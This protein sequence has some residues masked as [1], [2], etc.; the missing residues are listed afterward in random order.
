MT[1]MVLEAGTDR[2]DD[3]P[4]KAPGASPSLIGDSTYDWGFKTTEQVGLNGRTIN[5]PRGKLVGGS[6]AINSHSVVYPSQ[7][8]HDGWEQYGV[9]GWS[10][11][12]I[13]PYYQKFQTLC[14]PA[15]ES[16]SALHLN[17]VYENKSR[18]SG[19]IHTSFPRHSNP[20][21]AAWAETYEALGC[22]VKDDPIQGKA[23]GGLTVTN[24]IDP[25]K[26]ERSHAGV[27]YLKPAMD[28][29][30]V[31]IITDAL[32]EKIV[33]DPRY[34]SGLV[35]N[36]VQ[37]IKSGQQYIA[38]A[39]REVI[40]CAGAFQSPQIF[41]LSGI[42]SKS[43]LD[44]H[45]IVCLYDNPNVGENLQDHLNIGPSIE[46][47]DGVQTNDA[48][49]RDP[50][51]AE[52]ARKAYE[53]DHSGPLAEGAAYSFAY[54]P[55]SL[56]STPSE[57]D[58]LSA[59]FAC[60]P[61]T[62]SHFKAQYS[63][64]SNNLLTAPSAT[65][66]LTLRQRHSDASTLAAARSSSDPGNFISVIA[67]LSH[68][69]SRGRVHIT[70]SSP[71][72]YPL[73]DPAYLTH[74]LDVEI[75][76]R[77]LHGIDRLL[78]HEPLASF[79]KPGGSRLPASFP[80]PI[81][82]MSTADVES[83]IRRC[84]ATNY[85]P[86]GTCAMADS[87]RQGGVVDSKMRVHGTRNVRVCDASILPLIPR[88]NVLSTVYAVAERGADLIKGSFWEEDLKEDRSDEVTRRGLGSF[89]AGE[90]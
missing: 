2:S 22:A 83:M 31:E 44:S 82:Q 54:Q 37:Y 6:S 46:V 63:F 88:G 14:L 45:G 59:L 10:W 85:H 13:A 19:P 56:L 26:G 27:A 61:Q 74:P 87:I 51:F 65:L 66:F 39:R 60:T 50:T 49:S 17:Y 79:L 53:H 23:V 62:P 75:L 73:I 47:H 89:W 16:K 9:T 29:P 43:I 78:T 4:V 86:T 34:Q 20:L 40:I 12:E 42:G 8:Y 64:I 7:E 33:F 18:S 58:S 3:M 57:I 90:R 36:G 55:L 67:M 21:Q 24:A 77:H 71:H 28:R 35:A 76:A 38:K 70:S 30:N 72:D 81:A 52:R 5:H 25:N 48:S 32:V 15:E 80:L 68:P 84:V 1:V 41:E 69:F 11:K